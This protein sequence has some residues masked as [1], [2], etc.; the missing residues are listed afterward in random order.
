MGGQRDVGEAS[1]ALQGTHGIFWSS[2][3]SGA[4]AL[5][6]VFY[7]SGMVLANANIR[8]YGYSVRCIK[9]Q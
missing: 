8:G 5:R 1:L 3:V 2:D 7:A 6:V 4:S 9:D